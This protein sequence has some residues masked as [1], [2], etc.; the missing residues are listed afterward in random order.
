MPQ[1]HGRSP[2]LGPK[3]WRA[4]LRAW[5]PTWRF[6]DAPDLR[7]EVRAGSQ[8]P[9]I[10]LTQARQF[11]FWNL[12]LA[13]S[14]VD[15]MWW[16]GRVRAI[17]LRAQAQGKLSDTLYVE[18][19]RC[20]AALMRSQG[21]AWSPE[22]WSLRALDAMQGGLCLEIHCPPGLWRE[23]SGAECKEPRC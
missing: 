13:P 4:L 20:L 8:A 15:Q 14:L 9:W 2:V 10:A 16:E 18:L 12:A 22:G 21:K 5:T 6:F 19:D 17:V 3:P 11:R 1:N 7:L 23:E